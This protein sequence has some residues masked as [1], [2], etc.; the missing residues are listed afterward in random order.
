MKY[1]KKNIRPLKTEKHVFVSVTESL[2]KILMLVNCYANMRSNSA[3]V[4]LGV[5]TMSLLL[6]CLQKSCLLFLAKIE[7]YVYIYVVWTHHLLYF[8]HSL[9]CHYQLVCLYIHM[10]T[11]YNDQY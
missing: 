11:S 10:S 8:A 2:D 3:T 1:V 6:I 7:C 4:R 5:V 9:L